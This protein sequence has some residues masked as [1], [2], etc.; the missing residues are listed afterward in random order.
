M[1]KVISLAR[2]E[3][4][5]S[6]IIDKAIKTKL[7]RDTL[8]LLNSSNELITDLD[9]FAKDESQNSILIQRIIEILNIVVIAAL[10]FTL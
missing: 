10:Y 7:E 8:S 3:A 2:A 9:E 6:T 4:P 5:S 1:S